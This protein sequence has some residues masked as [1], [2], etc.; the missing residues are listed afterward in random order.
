MDDE[1][2]VTPT[3]KYE[4][5]LEKQLKWSLKNRGVHETN[6]Y[7]DKVEKAQNSLKY[8]AFEVD[9]G[10]KVGYRVRYV[11]D[12]SAFLYHVNKRTKTVTLLEYAGPDKVHLL[13][14]RA[15]NLKTKPRDTK[16]KQ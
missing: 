16:K 3:D 14:K 4:A 11:A 5:T 7:Q 8:G 13:T 2:T 15:E 6:K 1:Y 12:T 9:R 10:H